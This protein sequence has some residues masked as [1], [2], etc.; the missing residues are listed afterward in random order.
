[1]TQF[2]W[3]SRRVFVRNS[4]PIARKLNADKRKKGVIE[5]RLLSRVG[6]K[7]Q[8]FRLNA[9][10]EGLTTEKLVD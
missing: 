2:L 8:T 4:W 10:L 3:I 9:L 1:M 6:V 7:Y 5:R